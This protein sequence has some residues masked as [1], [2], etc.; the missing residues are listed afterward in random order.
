M[1]ALKAKQIELLKRVLIRGTLFL[2]SVINFERWT[3]CLIEQWLAKN[4]VSKEIC[5]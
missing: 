5:L 2:V 4:R 3:N 1:I